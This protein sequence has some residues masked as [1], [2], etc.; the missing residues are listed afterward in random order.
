MDHEGFRPKATLN[1]TI[2]ILAVLFIIGMAALVWSPLR[3]SSALLDSSYVGVLQFDRVGIDQ[4]QNSLIDGMDEYIINTLSK[5]NGV[6]VKRLQP[7]D[8]EARRSRH[9]ARFSYKGSLGRVKQIAEEHGVRYILT[10]KVHKYGD[11][12]RVSTR[13]IDAVTGDLVWINRYKD[14]IGEFSSVKNVIADKIVD[15][16]AMELVALNESCNGAEC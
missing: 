6:F 4:E 16:L 7:Q 2:S 15:D 5:R 11:N 10:G 9:R 13:L 1:V 14:S 12:F 3:S 8:Q